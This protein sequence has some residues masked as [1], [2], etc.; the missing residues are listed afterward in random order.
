LGAPSHV[1]SGDFIKEQP[2]NAQNVA[3]HDLTSRLES[4]PAHLLVGLLRRHPCD[5]K[6][7]IPAQWGEFVPR[8]EQISDRVSEVAYGVC[9]NSTQ[10]E[11]DY[12]CGVEVPMESSI[13]HGF[14]T[15]TLP[16]QHYA[17]FKHHGRVETIVDTVCQIFSHWLPSSGWVLAG[18]IDLVERYSADFDPVSNTGDVEI[19]IPIREA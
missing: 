5:N 18:D 14:V 1:L 3:P 15:L 7:G 17:V 19:W 6:S 8:I 16:P 9:V 11:F 10:T 2:M 13:P 12:F 4:K